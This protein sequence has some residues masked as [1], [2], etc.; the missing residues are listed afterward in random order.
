VCVAFFGYF[1]KLNLFLN[2]RSN[3]I[4]NY[5]EN[6]IKYKNYYKSSKNADYMIDNKNY[7][8]KVSSFDS[9]SNDNKK[10]HIVQIRLFSDIDFYHIIL[11]D[12]YGGI[13]NNPIV[14]NFILSKENMEK[15]CDIFK[16]GKAHSF[17]DNYIGYYADGKT[18]KYGSV[19]F[20]IKLFDSKDILSV[21][22]NRWIDN[23]LIE[24]TI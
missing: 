13:T 6:F 4:G 21:D 23:Y 8:L 2:I 10:A 3:D 19:R 1:F 14:Y 18:R 5:V 7:E 22:G 11:F 12:L 16:A 24:T 20:D 15:E 9:S 17:G